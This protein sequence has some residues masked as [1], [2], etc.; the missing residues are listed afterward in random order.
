MKKIRDI[1]PVIAERH[2]DGV[3]DGKPCKVVVRLGKPFPNPDDDSWCCPYSIRTEKSERVFFGAGVDSL[4]SLRM[5]ISMAGAELT[6]LF[7][8]LALKWA[9]EDDLG[10]SSQL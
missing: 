3:E 9:D 5:A 4:Q 7:S 2:L 1:G 6:T 8:H 10:F